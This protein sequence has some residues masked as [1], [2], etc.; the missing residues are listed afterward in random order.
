MTGGGIATLLYDT[1]N[2]NNAGTGGALFNA[3]PA[4]SVSLEDTLVTNN[5]TFPGGG[6]FAGAPFQSNGF[7]LTDDP[8]TAAAFGG[9][10]NAGPNAGSDNVDTLAGD[11]N[12]LGQLADNGGP[13][14]TYALVG[15]A[16][17]NKA[18]DGGDDAIGS[19]ATL[20][21]PDGFDQR[22]FDRIQGAHSDIGAF[23]SGALP[24][25]P[26]APPGGKRPSG[27]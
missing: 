6:S 22:G 15:T 25:P 19:Q 16:A 13:T 5:E 3:G 8:T 18:I 21:N 26:P 17:T 10:F 7:N 23:E 12:H 2:L 1:F 14:K 11:V 24:P 4:F 9:T 27:P 20:A